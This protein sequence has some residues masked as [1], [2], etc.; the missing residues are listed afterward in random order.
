MHKCGKSTGFTVH[1]GVNFTDIIWSYFN[2]YWP[3]KIQTYKAVWTEKLHI[4]VTFVQKGVH[5]MFV[6]LRLV[7]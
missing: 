7:L 3:Q 4:D 2:A 5:K 6:K 1:P